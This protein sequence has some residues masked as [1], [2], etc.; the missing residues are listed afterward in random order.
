MRIYSRG[1][2]HPTRW[3]QFRHHGPLPTARFDHHRPT[4]DGAPSDHL[5]RGTLYAA[6]P[7]ATAPA[8]HTCAL[9]VFRDRGI[10]N[11]Q[12]A[13]PYI[14]IFTTS[15][16]LTVLDLTDSDWVTRAG[17]NAAI[18]SGPRAPARTWA[19]AIY[20][21]YPGLHGVIYASSNLPTGRCVALFERAAPLIASSPMLNEPLAHAGLTPALADC[22]ARFNL[23][24]I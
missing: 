9:E 23:G 1:G 24:L 16:P 4:D 3:S 18:T 21:H 10:I 7:T 13:E 19:Q 17:G 22:A 8:L 11:T 2:E 15:E 5:N 14:A 20:A 6:I 12:L